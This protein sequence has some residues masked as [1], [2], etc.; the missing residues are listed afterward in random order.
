MNVIEKL[1]HFFDSRDALSV[2]S[3]AW[4]P[5][6][7]ELEKLFGTAVTQKASTSNS[8]PLG[9]LP[10][11]KTL[12]ESDVLF[13]IQCVRYAIVRA[14]K[15]GDYYKNEW[16]AQLAGGLAQSLPADAMLELTD[17]ISLSL[18]YVRLP[19]LWPALRRI[20]EKWSESEVQLPLPEQTQKFLEELHLRLQKENKKEYRPT[21]AQI[22][23]LLHPEQRGGLQLDFANLGTLRE[24][25]AG[26]IAQQQPAHG[27]LWREWLETCPKESEKSKPTE[28]WLKTTAKTLSSVP[29]EEQIRLVMLVIT[30]VARTLQ[31]LLKSEAPYTW[32]DA[33]RFHIPEWPCAVVWHI[34]AHGSQHP[35]LRAAL[36]KLTNQ[37]FKKV[38]GYGPVAP[39][40]GNACLRAYA[41]M[42]GTEGVGALYRFKTR[43][44][45]RNVI[46][47]TDNLL[48]EAA[49]RA[50]MSR[51]DLEDLTVPDFGL[52][53][54]LEHTE[55]IGGYT[56]ALAIR[57]SSE[58]VLEWRTADGK[59][60]KSAPAALR[61]AHATD[62]KR[63]QQSLKEL[64]DALT[65]QSARFE[66]FYLG[67]RTW[68][69]PMFRERFLQHPVLRAIAGRL[70]WSFEAEGHPTTAAIWH[71][72][73]WQHPAGGQPDWLDHE[74]TTVR[75]WHPLNEPPEQ[76]LVWRDWLQ[77]QQITQPFK[78]AYREIYVCTPPEAAT[79][80]YSNRF[81]AHILRQH[82]FASLCK[83]RGWHYTLQGQWE[84]HN[85]PRRDVAGWDYRVEFWAE[86]G[87]DSTPVSEAGIF[88]YVHTDQVRFQHLGEWVQMPDV[89][90]LLFSE[91]M[92]DVDMFVGVC[93][94]GNDPGWQD[95]GDS[96]Y[97]AYWQSFAFAEDLTANGEVRKAALER[98]IPRLKIAG[99][100]RFEG[101]FLLVKG[102]RHTYKIHCGSGNILMSPNDQYLCIVPDS[103]AKA[104]ADQPKVYL[105]FEG[106]RLLSIIISKA[107]LL[108]NDDKIKDS[109]I[110]RQL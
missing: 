72:G 35:E 57:Q 36:D 26:E 89:P 13:R 98:I 110:L 88:L 25:L 93:S 64:R 106:D 14:E 104:S 3:A 6:A 1:R 62:L 5:V 4:D 8:Y 16:W 41:L 75:L 92:R 84:S 107:L 54:E 30:Q 29:Q 7:R 58:A 45:N 79:L 60:L 18:K 52:N 102:T 49:L 78:Q 71:E 87:W 40:L 51:A 103:S 20:V 12:K 39:K 24:T 73:R 66:E 10:S 38:A 9:T 47:L 32:R 108:A 23:W 68:A 43:S 55:T 109:S 91:L 80:T 70:I 33:D 21:M 65:T 15:G 61:S 56:A 81:A 74:S 69:S 53:A 27:I 83:L 90:P 2:G 105:P 101:K 77:N 96:R 19:L 11:Y 100:C 97:Q 50:G 82:Q 95:T 59:A 46:K 86:A 17:S 31:D 76:V 94:I 99:Q 85:T 63:L 48:N 28:K 44:S 37:C 67:Q 42:P 22:K 34:G